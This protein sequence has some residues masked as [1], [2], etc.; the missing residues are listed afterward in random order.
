MSGF[1]I[2]H[3]TPGEP[4][5]CEGAVNVDPE[6]AKDGKVWTMTGTLAS[7][8]LTLSPSVLCTRHPE[9]HAHILN[10]RWTG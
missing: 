2:A 8:D 7:G 1:I 9:F 6:L 3:D 4:W 10:G 5:R